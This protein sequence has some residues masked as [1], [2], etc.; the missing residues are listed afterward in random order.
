M[1]TKLGSGWAEIGAA[2]RSKSDSPTVWASTLLGVGQEKYCSLMSLS[3]ASTTRGPRH[4]Y[5]RYI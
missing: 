1:P 2:M 4:E 3:A 5:A